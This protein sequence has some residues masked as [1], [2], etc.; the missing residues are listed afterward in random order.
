MHAFYLTSI[1]YDHMYD[2]IEMVPLLIDWRMMVAVRSG[3]VRRCIEMQQADLFRFTGGF[4][5]CFRG[6]LFRCS[7]CRLPCCSLDGAVFLSPFS[8][9]LPE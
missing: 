4:P 8:G 9:D 7:P 3:D 6:R 1:I 5:G 2:F